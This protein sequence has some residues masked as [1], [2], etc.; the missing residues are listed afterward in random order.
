M[1][2]L[3]LGQRIYFAAVGLLALWVGT[4]GYFIPARVDAAIPWLVPPLHSRFLGSMYLSGFAFMLG[5]I[6]ARRWA[7][8][9]VVVPMIAIWTGMLFI[10]SLFYLDQF[11]YSRTQ[12]WI[13][14]AAYLIYPLIAL[15]LTWN[16]RDDKSSEKK[17]SAQLPTWCKI[18]LAAQG[19][20]VTALA[21]ALLF[22]PTFMT[23]LWPWKITPLLAQIYSS[24]FLSYGIGSLLLS[25]RE[26]WSETRIAIIATL[27]FSAGVFIASLLHRNLFTI[28]ETADVLWFSGFGVATI[29]L[30]FLTLRAFSSSEVEKP[31]STKTVATPIS[32]WLRAW[33][34]VEV[35]FGLSAILT[36]GLFPAQTQTNF[37][38]HIQVVVMA[39]VLGG[40]YIVSSSG[41]VLQF[42]S[43]RWETIRVMVLPAILFTSLQLLVTFLHW[44]KFAH[45]TRGFYVWFASYLLPP[46]IFLIAYLWHQRRA[47]PFIAYQPLPPT[48]RWFFFILGSI[49]VLD[50]I[51]TFIFPDL[52]MTTFPWKLTP[53][54]TRSL[55]GWLA[56]V[57]ALMLSVA[58]ENDRTRVRLASP[59]FILLLPILS[60]Q[61]A[62]HSSEVNWD[63]PRIW[64]N[65]V[66]LAIVCLCG[67]ELARGNWR[68]ALGWGTTSGSAHAADTRRGGALA[69]RKKGRRR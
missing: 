66:I 41:I 4:W 40:F 47:A 31:G 67:L 21:L 51:I 7:E 54:T 45:G 14:F 10:V 9:R 48:L 17:F 3:T 18:Y 43:K 26:Y 28:N 39:A 50:A 32:W 65:L 44:D 15:W 33:L 49:F 13:W 52:F 46:P 57:G 30:G 23:S 34:G 68:E 19:V 12:V 20:V 5:C 59:I 38:W 2:P 56:V 29:A 42:L 25:R 16:Y 11:D 55:C 36:I 63:H 62:L 58:R 8:V 24:P 64:I 35:L 6:F 37:A 27:V 69:S 60:I 1:T 22:M 61:V 53:L